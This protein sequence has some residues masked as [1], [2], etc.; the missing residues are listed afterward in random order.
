MFEANWLTGWI[1]ESSSFYE[2]LLQN[3]N[4]NEFM[5]LLKVNFIASPTDLSSLMTS[6]LNEILVAPVGIPSIDVP[7]PSLYNEFPY[8]NIHKGDSLESSPERK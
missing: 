6:L 4:H 8:L 7:F 1:A 3:E 5:E 2:S